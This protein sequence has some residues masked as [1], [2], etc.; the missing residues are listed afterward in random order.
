MQRSSREAKSSPSIKY[1]I[2]SMSA[3]ET[4][5]DI[6]PRNSDVRFVPNADILHCGTERRYLITSSA[7]GSPVLAQC[8]PDIAICHAKLM[9]IF[10][11]APE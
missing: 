4:K 1:T 10:G 5:A 2:R 6:R 8:C 11:M 9:A 3:F 7:R